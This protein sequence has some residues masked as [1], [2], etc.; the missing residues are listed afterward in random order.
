[1]DNVA[2]EPQNAGVPFACAAQEADLCLPL[3]EG[4]RWFVA[5]TLW[6]S[7]KTARFHLGAQGFR[8][9]LPRFHKTVRHARQLREVIAPIFPGYIFVVLNPERDR[10][11]SINGTFGVAR[12]IS[13][14]QRPTPVPTGVVEALLGRLDQSGLVR[15]DD[16][17]K[18]GQPVRVI[19][20]AFAG[21][22]GVLQRLDAKGRVQVLL[23]IMGG[24]APATMDRA[25]LTAA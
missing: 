24:Q 4:E 7:E 18:P 5:Q 23:N 9:F 20:G 19:A 25:N 11:R 8:T 17:L 10:W 16:R 6:H 1:M 22:L 21:V 12:L 2:T 3:C 14:D 15:F 13:A